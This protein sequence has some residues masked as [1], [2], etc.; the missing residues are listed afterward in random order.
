[1][2]TKGDM[3][4]E[5][6]QNGEHEAIDDYCLCDTLDT[7][8]VFLRTQV[9]RGMVSRE[10]EGMLVSQAYELL[11][12]KAVYMPIL[13]KYLEHFSIWQETGDDD[14]PFYRKQRACSRLSLTLSGNDA[15]GRGTTR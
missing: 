5:M 13:T 1:M 4:Q 11:Q 14:D 12:Q 15:A 6:W 7:Y 3:V 2:D 9:L 8:F 10:R